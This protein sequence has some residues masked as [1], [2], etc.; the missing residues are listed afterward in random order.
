MHDAAGLAYLD[1][2]E[3][4]SFHRSHRPVRGP[5]SVCMHRLDARTVS[6]SQLRASETELSF[7]YA[8]GAP[9]R[10]ALGPALILDRSE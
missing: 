10:A 8:Q 7:R 6:Y 2:Q 4:L 5:W 3:R 1:P 9:C